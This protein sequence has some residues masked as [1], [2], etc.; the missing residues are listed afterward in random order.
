MVKSMLIKNAKVFC[1]DGMFTQK[2]IAVSRSRFSSKPDSSKEINASGC[3]AIPGLIDLHTHGCVGHDFSAA[4]VEDIH[5]MTAFLAKNGITA[6]CPATLTLPEDILI[7]ACERIKKAAATETAGASIVGINLE[8]PFLSP[9]KIGAQNPAHVR[10]PD[11]EMY[12][13]LQSTSDGLVKLLSIAPEL[14][15]ALELISALKDEV[16]LSLAHT[17]ADYD[18]TLEAIK[19]GATHVTHLFNAMPPFTHREPGAIGAIFDSPSCNVEII[20]D[21]VHI[22]PA[23]VRAAFAMF[24]DER[25]VLISDSM[26]ATGL[27]EGK[28]ELGGI[29]VEVKGNTA[30][31][32]FGGAIAGSVVTLLDVVQTAVT[33]MNIPLVSAVKCATVNPAKVLGVYDEHGSIDEGKYANLIL[34]NEKDLSVREVILRGKCVHNGI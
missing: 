20:A 25:I 7:R 10:L 19:L 12:R 32:V 17:A 2:D 1:S 16:R 31:L 33:Q 9:K 8:G 28:Y 3:Y 14:P 13:R 18:L 11:V 6:V 22:H 4:N 29:E 23:V 15:G 27:G 5:M 24:G 21:G 30:R 34:L 26:M